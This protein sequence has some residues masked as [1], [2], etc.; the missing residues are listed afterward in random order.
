MVIAYR[1][2]NDIYFGKPDHLC[3]GTNPRHT[4]PIDPYG[5]Y[6]FRVNLVGSLL[7]EVH[8]IQWNHNTSHSKF[9]FHK[10]NIQC[11]I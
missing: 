8:N 9:D 2:I 11:A 10:P 3:Y 7:D 4:M 5:Q 1:D 6:S